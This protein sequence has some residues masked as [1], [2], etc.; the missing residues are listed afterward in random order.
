ME[1]VTKG[2]GGQECPTYNKRKEGRL[3]G[4]VTSLRRNCLLIHVIEDKIEGRIEVTG[5]GERNVTS[6]CMA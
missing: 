5:G 4:V 2:Q 6:Y 1:S 3:T